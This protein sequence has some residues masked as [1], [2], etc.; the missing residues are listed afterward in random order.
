MSCP[1]NDL[2]IENCYEK[3]TEMAYERFPEADD[4]TP[5]FEEIV[6]KIYEQ[7]LDNYPEI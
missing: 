3:A 7:L 4:S 5:E 2:M 1:Y 6:E